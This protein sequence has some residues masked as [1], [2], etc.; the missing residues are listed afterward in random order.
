MIVQPLSQKSCCEY[1]MRLVIVL[2][3]S[4]MGNEW[5]LGGFFVLPRLSGA[6]DFP[7]TP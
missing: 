1:C 3:T 6:P 2:I 5:R 7:R 4:K